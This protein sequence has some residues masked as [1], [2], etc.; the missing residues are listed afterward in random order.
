MAI[1]K[2]WKTCNDSE[3]NALF[4]EIIHEAEN[5]GYCPNIRGRLMIFKHTS[6]YGECRSTKIGKEYQSNIGVNQI[7]LT[8]HPALTDVLVHEIAHAIVPLDKHG[9]K[10]KEVGNCIGKKFR[11]NVVRARPES[12]Y[13]QYGVAI[14]RDDEEG[15][16]II[17]CP[18]CHRQSK[19]FRKSKV[20]QHPEQYQCNYCKTVLV[21][22]K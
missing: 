9:L 22:I 5:L 11:C 8:S 6:M 3:A 14:S 21:R 17:G 10:W 16:Y 12:F 18:Q 1:P 7:V 4:D 13:E 19:Y 15:K 2:T 20:V